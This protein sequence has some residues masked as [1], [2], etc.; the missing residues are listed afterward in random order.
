[1]VIAINYKKQASNYKER[2]AK[3]NIKTVSEKHQLLPG[4][5]FIF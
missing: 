4:L 5:I 2:R 1:V 3:N